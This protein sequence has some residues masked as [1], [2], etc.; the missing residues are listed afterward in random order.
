MGLVGVAQTKM[1]MWINV[2]MIKE[3]KENT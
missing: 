2:K 3:K 1:H